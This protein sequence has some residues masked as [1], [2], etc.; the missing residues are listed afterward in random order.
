MPGDN[1][2]ITLNEVL[3]QRSAREMMTNRPAWD[4]IFHGLGMID[5]RFDQFIN[6]IEKPTGFVWGESVWGVDTVDAEASQYASAYGL[7]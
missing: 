5:E 4:S 6:Q 1:V 7:A 2:G 3:A